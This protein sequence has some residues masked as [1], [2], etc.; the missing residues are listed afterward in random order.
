[1]TKVVLEFGV[2]GGAH[3]ENII[4]PNAKLAARMAA[5]LHMTFKNDPTLASAK[6]IKTW[7]IS[8][9]QTRVTWTDSKHFV[10]VTMLGSTHKGPASGHLW[11]G[12]ETKPTDL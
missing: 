6:E 9:R 10:S 2:C 7:T 12:Q 11:K 4:V 8:A 3:T 5:C 1:M